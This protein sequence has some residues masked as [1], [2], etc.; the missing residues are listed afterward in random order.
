MAALTGLTVASMVSGYLREMCLAAAFG[1]G[2]LA[3][4][5]LSVMTTIRLVCDCGPSA[6][7]LASVIPVVSSLLDRPARLRGHVL[8]VVLAVT[9]AVTCGMALALH[10]A[11]PAL[12]TVLAPGFDAATRDTGLTLAALTVWFMPLQSASVLFSLFLNAHGRFR[13]AAAA[14]LVSNGVF[15]VVLTLAGERAADWLWIATLLGPGLTTVL[16][17]LKA[18]RMGLFCFAPCPETRQ[19]LRA[20]WETARPVLFSLGLAGSTGLVMICHLL[21]RRH[22]S[23]V[24]EGGVSALAYAFRLYEVP[25]SMTANIAATLVLPSLSRLH[26]AG[27]DTRL[28]EIC[29]ELAEWGLLLLVPVAA[30]TVLEASFLVDVLLAHGRFSAEDASRT[31]AALKRFAPAIVFESGIV[32][33][34][35][36]L[37]AVRRPKSALTVSLVIIGSLGGLLALLPAP[38]VTH[39][40]LAFSACFGLGMAVLAVILFRLLGPQVLPFHRGGGAAALLLLSACAAVCVLP[41]APPLLAGLAFGLAYIAAF[42]AAMPRHRA[43]LATLLFRRKASG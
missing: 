10:F 33:F 13:A 26:A 41:A 3:D 4:A 27:S 22:G 38:E 2:A 40:A 5:Y 43:A 16:L 20:L 17:G 28:T 18:W 32:V 30:F 6:I 36:V 39:P 19:A 1:A 34:Y 35:R 11:M 8:V 31:A 29:R 9:L 7:L 14:P 24:G 42:M 12:L 37:Y 21:V 25:V 15:V 23:L